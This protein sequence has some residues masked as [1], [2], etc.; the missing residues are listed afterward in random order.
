MQE[1]VEAVSK[2]KRRLLIIIYLLY[3]L[4]RLQPP[5]IGG[6]VK[7]KRKNIDRHRLAGADMLEDGYFKDGV[8]QCAQ[9][10]SV[11]LSDE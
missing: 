9:K 10:L 11:R 1:E 7:R 8:T 3:L 2:R 6:S 5:R 4:V